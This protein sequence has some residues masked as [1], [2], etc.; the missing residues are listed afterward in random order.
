MQHGAGKIARFDDEFKLYNLIKHAE[1]SI[2]LV[3]KEKDMIGFETL[4]E[5][6]PIPVVD[7][8]IGCREDKFFTKQFQIIEDN[9]NKGAIM[10]QFSIMNSREQLDYDNKER[11]A[12]EQQQRERKAR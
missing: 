10:V 7:I 5:T 4:G 2:I 11:R 8:L 3:A 1:E 6:K 12:Q 9:K